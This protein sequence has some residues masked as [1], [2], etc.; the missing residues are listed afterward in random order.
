MSY[1][2]H[3][4]SAMSEQKGALHGRL[5]NEATMHTEGMTSMCEE[6]VEGRKCGRCVLF[7]SHNART[8]DEQRNTSLALHVRQCANITLMKL[9]THETRHRVH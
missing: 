3:S 9:H 2:W 5:S 1:F 4:F 7:S 6:E 8:S